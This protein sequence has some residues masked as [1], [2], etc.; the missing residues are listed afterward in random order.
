MAAAWD[1]F[2]WCDLPSRRSEHDVLLADNFRRCVMR[3]ASA[4]AH[5]VRML[6]VQDPVKEGTS[7]G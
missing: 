2:G 4:P 6:M 7:R 1:V 5:V 3:C